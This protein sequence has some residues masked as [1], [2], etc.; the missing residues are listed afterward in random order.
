M[1]KKFVHVR[2]GNLIKAF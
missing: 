2:L 1:V